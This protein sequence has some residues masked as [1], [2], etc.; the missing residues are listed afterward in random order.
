MHGFGVQDLVFGWVAV[1]AHVALFGALARSRAPRP[2]QFV[3]DGVLPLFAGAL[4]AAA[5]PLAACTSPTRAPDCGSGGLPTLTVSTIVAH[6]PWSIPFAVGL[7]LVA[8]GICRIMVTEGAPIC[9][10]FLAALITTVGAYPARGG[11]N[12][13]AHYAALASAGAVSA[14]FVLACS[15]PDA[16]GPARSAVL[17]AHAA[18]AFAWAVASAV[19]VWVTSLQKGSPALLGVLAESACLLHIVAAFL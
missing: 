7:V 8:F 9:G 5:T 16:M 14:G 11:G 13:T 3:R 10:Y 6:A 12:S 18:M 15:T 19:P 1:A 17:R 4:V 2:R